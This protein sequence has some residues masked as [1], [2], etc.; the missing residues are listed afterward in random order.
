MITKSFK[1][2]ILEAITLMI[3][4][5][6]DEAGIGDFII[7][8]KEKNEENFVLIDKEQKGKALFYIYQKI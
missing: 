4:E 8:K 5:N 1:S 7:S 2:K 3:K 6:K